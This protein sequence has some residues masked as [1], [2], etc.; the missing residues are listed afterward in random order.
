M[1][2]SAD[3]ELSKSPEHNTELS[4]HDRG[5]AERAYIKT[6][7]WVELPFQKSLP[8]KGGGGLVELIN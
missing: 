2:K 8:V 7:S 5:L 1:S 3:L 4:V 6:E